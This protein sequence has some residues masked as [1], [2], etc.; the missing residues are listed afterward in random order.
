MNKVIT[1]NLGGV[2]YQLEDGG[3]EA[4]RDYLDTAARRLEGNPDKDEIIADIEQA[5]GDKF[6]GM[7]GDHKTVIL[8]K[9]VHAVITEMG[10]VQDASGSDERAAADQP[11]GGA[12]AAGATGATGTD[13]PPL[14]RLYKIRDGAMLAGVCNGLAAY[15]NVDAAFVR[16]GFALMILCWGAGLLA[17]VILAIILPEAHTPAEKAAATGA[18]ATAEEFIRRAKAGYYDGMRSFGDKQAHREWRR[19]FKREMR[20]WKHGFRR[21]M[22]EHTAYGW[23]QPW[24]QHPPSSFGTFVVWPI[25]SVFKFLAFLVLVFAVLSLTAYGS[26]WGV[27]LPAGIPFW[28]GIIFLLAAYRVI[29][30]PVRMARRAWRYPGWSYGGYYPPVAGLLNSIV[31]LALAGFLIWLADRHVPGFHAKLQALPAEAQRFMESV[32]EWWARL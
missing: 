19:R 10:P 4:L 28:I 5:I 25:L 1:I 30:W 31:W 12:H 32:R 21:E 24:A 26:V 15:L 9:E 16:V 20:E 13:R 3:Y 7:L 11:A 14:R 6:R 2:A 8:T 23:S 18:A 17:Y 27:A 29:T 22:R